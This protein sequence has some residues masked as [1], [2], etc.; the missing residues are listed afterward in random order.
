[1]NKRLL[2]VAAFALAGCVTVVAQDKKKEF[3]MPT[4]YAGITHEMSEFYEPVPPVV[5]PGTD[6]KGGGFTA[7]SDAIVLFDGKDLSAW[8]SVKGRR[9]TSR[10]N[11][12]STISRC[13]S[14]GRS[15]RILPVRASR[16]VTAVFSC[17]G[18]MR[19]KC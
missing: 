1:M 7:P 15:R 18:C 12:N 14:S 9:V 11:R 19:F 10:P 3:K 13:T 17:K 4:G 6:L 16:E 5:T 2:T 8:E